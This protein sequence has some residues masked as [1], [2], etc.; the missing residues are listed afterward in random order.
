MSTGAI[1]DEAAGNIVHRGNGTGTNSCRRSILEVK[2]RSA[3]GQLAAVPT[4]TEIE[5]MRN[6]LVEKGLEFILRSVREVE[7]D[8]G[9]SVSHFAVGVELL[10]KARIFDEHWSLVASKPHAAEWE[11]MKNGSTKTLAASDLVPALTSL[12]GTRLKAEEEVFKKLFIHRNQVLHFVPPPTVQLAAAEQFLGWY[13]LHRLMTE[14]WPELFRHA[15]MKI[16]EVEAAIR[17]HDGFLAVIFAQLTDQG[18]LRGGRAV[19]CAVCNFASCL[20]PLVAPDNSDEDP[21]AAS[22]SLMTSKCLVCHANVEV[23]DPGCGYPSVASDEYAGQGGINCECG[24]NHTAEEL[25]QCLHEGW[26]ADC[27]ACQRT[28]TVTAS[29]GGFLCLACG[30][31]W[32][33]GEAYCCPGCDMVWFGVEP[34]EEW[35]SCPKCAEGHAP[36]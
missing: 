10:L 20:V 29:G 17:T 4:R 15:R 6:R 24:R 25:A 27:T 33:E 2:L 19:H 26:V 8:P 30:L 9:I 13:H 11:A 28:G 34:E 18:K 23:I 7:K 3:C 5:T 36:W 32:C 14:K 1:P 31:G 12:T 22:M 35:D 16:S 21:G